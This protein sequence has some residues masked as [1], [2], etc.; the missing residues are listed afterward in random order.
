MLVELRPRLYLHWTLFVLGT[1]CMRNLTILQHGPGLHALRGAGGQ[2]AT[3]DLLM[4]LHPTNV[5]PGYV[6]PLNNDSSP[7]I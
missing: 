3:R 1:E 6:G 7:E 5:P 4:H 2:A